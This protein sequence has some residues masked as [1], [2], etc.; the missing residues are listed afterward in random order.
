MEGSSDDLRE[1][2]DQAWSL[3]SR[4]SLADLEMGLRVLG[5]ERWQRCPSLKGD[6]GKSLLE[7]TMRTVPTKRFGC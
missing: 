3:S 1:L 6:P 2:C 4:C 7:V 5:G